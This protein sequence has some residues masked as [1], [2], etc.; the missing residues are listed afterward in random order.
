MQ[1]AWR[2]C[3]ASLQS[4]LTLAVAL[5]P[6]RLLQ[7]CIANIVC[8]VLLISCFSPFP[9]LRHPIRSSA[10]TLFSLAQSM[11]GMTSSGRQGAMAK[12][13]FADADRYRTT[14]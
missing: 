13:R 2:C 10:V 9:C 1:V 4:C 5:Q 14:Y 7:A 12:Q 8:D 11:N 6:I 3:M